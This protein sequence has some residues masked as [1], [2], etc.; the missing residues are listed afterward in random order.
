VVGEGPEEAL[1][2]GE[3][4]GA[5]A[6]AGGVVGFGV[7]IIFADEVGGE[8]GVVVGVGLAV[9][10]VGRVERKDFQTGLE[11]AEEELVIARV[12]AGGL[13]ERDAVGGSVGETEAEIVGLDLG[14]GGAFGAGTGGGDAGQ[15]AA[16]GIAGDD[17]GRDAGKE[18]MRLGL[19]GLDAVEG[20]AELGVGLAA[21]AVGDAGLGHEIALVGGV[22]EHFGADDAAGFEADRGQ[23]GA[24]FLDG[25][26]E[27]EA[28]AAEDGEVVLAHEVLE[29][30]FR[31]VRLEGPHGGLA[32]VGGGLADAAIR[33]DRLAGPGL[34]ARVVLGDALV[35]LAGEAA[36]GAFVADVGL[37]EA[38]AAEAAEAGVGADENDGV[39]ETGGL[40]G[41]H[42]AAGG[43]AVDADFGFDG[44]GHGGAG[45]A[46]GQGEAAEEGERGFHGG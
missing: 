15:E 34:G 43:A 9:R 6:V 5:D 16:G 30:F 37:A 7:G 41:G 29:D 18:L 24:G 10:H 12:V 23:A 8:A 40:D 13:G 22:D 36:D 39:A 19:P 21:D 38:A 33:A 26:G 20:F 31:D 14:V 11:V 27:I 35:E 1:G 4:G 25:A 17:V 3:V 44:R 42:D 46:E 2:V 32:G 28:L 45:G